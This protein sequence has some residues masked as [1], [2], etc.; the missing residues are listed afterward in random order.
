M[1]AKR[2]KSMYNLDLPT[3]LVLLTYFPGKQRSHVVDGRTRT[4]EM[5]HTLKVLDRMVK[6]NNAG[7]STDTEYRIELPYQVNSSVFKYR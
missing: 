6:C 2:V 7:S 5:K 4:T 1:D 3:K